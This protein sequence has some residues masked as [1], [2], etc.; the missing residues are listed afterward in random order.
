MTIQGEL[1]LAKLSFCFVESNFETA[2]RPPHSGY[3]MGT[4]P[5]IAVA[6]STPILHANDT[7]PAVLPGDTISGGIA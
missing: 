7:F 3:R 6:C 1:Q 5:R 2:D 4:P